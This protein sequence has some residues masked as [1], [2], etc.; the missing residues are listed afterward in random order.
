MISLGRHTDE[1]QLIGRGGGRRVAKDFTAGNGSCYARD[2]GQ[3]NRELA[4]ARR[5]EFLQGVGNN[6]GDEQTSVGRLLRIHGTVAGP[7]A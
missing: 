1:P 7:G 6:V 5:V 3:W 2:S 4:D